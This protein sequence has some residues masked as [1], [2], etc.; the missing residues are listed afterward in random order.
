MAVES[1]RVAIIDATAKNV[2]KRSRDPRVC[3][4]LAPFVDER[5]ARALFFP[6]PKPSCGEW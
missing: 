2:L 4:T 3:K 6:L 5:R 1:A